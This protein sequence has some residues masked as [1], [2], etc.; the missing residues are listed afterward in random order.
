M[1]LIYKQHF[2][3]K[4]ATI[5][6]KLGPTELGFFK[7]QHD[8]RCSGPLLPQYGSTLGLQGPHLGKL[9]QEQ[10]QFFRLATTLGIVT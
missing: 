3:L 6:K 10:Q 1:T 9:N 7:M 4:K 2:F 5:R 8:I